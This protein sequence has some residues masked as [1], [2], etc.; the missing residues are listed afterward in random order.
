MGFG[1]ATSILLLGLVA[2]IL[3]PPSIPKLSLREAAPISPVKLPELNGTRALQLKAL[4]RE[5][6]YEALRVA[7]AAPAR[8]A[9]RLP[10]NPTALPQQTP[11]SRVAPVTAGFYVSWDD[12]SLVSLRTNLAK[13]DWVIGEWG[14]IAP[15]GDSVVIRVDRRA[16]FVMQQAPADFR[17]RAFLM[18]TDVD[19]SGQIFM[20]GAALR[21][22]AEPFRSRAIDALAGAAITFGLAGVVI[23]LEEL[24]SSAAPALLSFLSALRAR[25][26]R[27][28]RIVLATTGVDATN[29]ELSDLANHVDRV[30]LMAYDEHD[31][32]GDAGPVASNAWFAAQIARA[33]SVVP[34]SSLIVG[35]AGYGYDWNDDTPHQPAEE[36]TFQ[37]AMTYARNN[38]A[39]IRFDA[40]SGN[41]YLMWSD[42]DS[43]DHVAWFLDAAASFNQIAMAR[44]HGAAGVALWRLGSEDPSLWRALGRGATL[45]E[46]TLIDSIPG[47]YDVQFDGVGEIL[48]VENRPKE[49]VRAIS[50]DSVAQLIRDERYALLPL[51]YIVQR[52]GLA[53]HRIALTF[54]DGP[55]GTW[56]AAILD[57]LRSRRAPATFFVIG[58]N[59]QAHLALLRQTYDEGHEIGNHTF[60]HPNLALTSHFVTRLEIDA[61]ERL[62]EAAL[63]RRSAFFR[64]P[65]FGDAEPT[66]SDELVPV[67]IATDLGFLTAGLHIDSDDWR[68]PGT[69]RILRN[70]LD[71]SAAGSIVLLHDGGGDRSQ[72]VAALGRMIDSLR[73]RGD[74]I[75]GLSALIGLTREQAMPPLPQ[76]SV[77]ARAFELVAFGTLGTVEWVLRW[78]FLIAI[79]LGIA[80]VV[81]MTT[82]A[83]IQRFARRRFTDETHPYG[84]PVSVIVPA[85]NEG[86]VVVA[87]VKSLLAS[88]YDGPL[89]ILVVDD[90]SHDD[91]VDVAQR[92]FAGDHRVTVMTKENGGKASALNY[93]IA[94][95][96]GD[97]IIGLDADT[98]FLPETIHDLVQP[99][100]DL[101]VGAAAGNA[102]VGNRINLVT[103][104][105]ALEYITSQNLDRRAFALLDCITVVP[106][107][108]GAWRKSA[109]DGVGGFRSD[110]LAEDQDLTIRLH[111]AG[112]SV[113]YVDSAIAYTE[114]PDSLRGLAKQRFRWSFGTLQCV[115]KH[116]AVLFRPAQRALG[117][118]AFPCVWLFQLIFPALSPAADLLFVWSLISFWL[119]RAQHGT[120]YALTNLRE[121]IT[122]YAIF[123]LID[124]V[125]AILA[126]LLEPTEQFELTPLVAMQRFIYRQVMYGV[127][128]RAFIA[129]AHGKLVGWG[130]LDRKATVARQVA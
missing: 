37:D 22:F 109:V 115:W 25:L 101:R 114:A 20:Q 52:S 17:P 66:S 35:I 118:F 95:A 71:R 43:T 78:F 89:E 90:G 23:D 3:I 94:R 108:V 18:L 83:Y 7:P 98:V 41:P 61:T 36:L 107:A 6:L 84:P 40:A 26:A 69:E 50:F 44:A 51:P 4:A 46:A 53:K 48:R 21:L 31:S 86:K 63:D 65:Y 9:S 32:Q 87:T 96:N 125:G 128:I 129:A 106:G 77:T 82:L 24:P 55:D 75:V 99:L 56:T 88:R 58:E 102:K 73:A 64:P 14:F 130:K 19:T 85:Y 68:R 103:R 11:A 80:R 72:T 104:L 112:W 116:R 74:T 93:G 49:G 113:A 5:R 29:A 1:I 100:S 127:V 70:V 28:G 120:T 124:W 12:N 62:I 81:V 111:R 121:L 16:L 45:G 97:V 126:F 27:D 2:A 39:P 15:T 105:Q 59:A 13:L 38:H 33:A 91:T 54:D 57:T 10:L 123:L 42:P 34:A 117:M 47:G 110:T 119:V 8:H 76:G 30:I 122:L 60:T 92:A 67:G 79:V